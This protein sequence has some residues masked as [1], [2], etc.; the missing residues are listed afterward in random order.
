MNVSVKHEKTELNRRLVHALYDDVKRGDVEAFFAR[1]APDV[2]V[3]RPPFLPP[4]SEYHGVESL[5]SLL[6]EVPAVLD[7][8]NLTVDEIV[9]D[10]D[11]VVAFLRVPPANG[12]GL[13]SVVEAFRLRDGLVTEI[14]VSVHDASTV[15][16]T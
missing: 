5:K 2:V 10:G 4:G 11:R 14:S 16:L 6:A 15:P 13:A 9:A 7:L 8:G 1:L 12:G 3:K